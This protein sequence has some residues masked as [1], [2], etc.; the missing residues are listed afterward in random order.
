MGILADF[1]GTTGPAMQTL[2]GI[3]SNQS[4]NAMRA[5]QTKALA[6]QN[7]MLQNQI[8][9][10]KGNGN[11]STLN[12]IAG[13]TAP[14]NND[15]PA[16]NNVP[17]A[18]GQ[19]PTPGT[20]PNVAGQPSAAPAPSQYD[21]LNMI[22][23]SLM[24]RAQAAFSAGDFPDGQALMKMAVKFGNTASQIQSRTATA[25]KAQADIQAQN[26]ERFSS[27][28]G[29]VHDQAGWDGAITTALQQRLITPNEF[30]QLNNTP[31]SPAIVD[32]LTKAGT[33]F[34]QQ[35]RVAQAKA[36]DK[37]REEQTA[38]TNAYRNMYLQIKETEARTQEQR[39]QAAIKASGNKTA[40]KLNPLS[41]DTQKSALAALN[42]YIPSK[43]TFDNGKPT[44]S[45]QRASQIT[46]FYAQQLTQ[47]DPSLSPSAALNQAASTLS[48]QQVFNVVDGKLKI[49]NN[50]YTRYNPAPFPKTRADAQYGR[51]YRNQ[52]GDV[53]QWTTNGWVK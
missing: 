14:P 37:F 46:A 4:V 52:S 12:N 20:N 30:A 29:G 24:G 25:Q 50:G 41:P 51:W 26:A 17:Q 31:Y 28:L 44:G 40:I 19:Q 5:E 10:W 15:A 27:L 36:L 18:Q 6:L 48:T 34:A 39:A 2:M 45:A 3:Q 8:N 42:T 13:N 43:V 16:A 47:Q 21:Q 53:I 23:Q 11:L 38:A 49:S 9:F 35:S 22:S 1:A 7:E 33:T 32:R